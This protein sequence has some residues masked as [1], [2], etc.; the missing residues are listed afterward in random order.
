MNVIFAY[1]GREKGLA[2]IF[3]ANPAYLHLN[4]VEGA[5]LYGCDQDWFQ[6]IWQRK[7]GCGP[8]TLANIMLYLARAGKL[9]KPL[10]ARDEQGMLPIMETMWEYV[11]PG[12]RGLNCIHRFAGGANQA[13]TEAGCCLRAICFD[14]EE[15]AP[16]P[17]RADIVHYIQAG[18]AKAPVAFLSLLRR[19]LGDL[20]PWHWVTVAGLI[21]SGDDTL[22]HI[23]D[24]GLAFDLSLR[25]W[26]EA[27]GTG[28]FVAFA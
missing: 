24:N 14:V 20:E 22:L 25:A 19:Q 4:N 18:L 15:G 10:A 6:G 17:E 3:V 16:R 11:T 27:G 7:S 13:L 28:G 5:T 26:L 23:Y 21:P 8:C 1:C 12:I 2:Q 9:E